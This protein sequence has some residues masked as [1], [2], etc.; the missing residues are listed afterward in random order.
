VYATPRVGDYI[1]GFAGTAGVARVTAINSASNVTIAV[2]GN[3][4]AQNSVTG[5]TTNTY[6]SKITNKY[7]Y[8]FTSDGHPDSTSGPATFLNNGGFNPNKYRYVLGSSAGPNAT[9]VK[10]QSA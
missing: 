3:V 6:A 1:I 5:V 7:V 4:A 8:D 10:V 2:T 9:F